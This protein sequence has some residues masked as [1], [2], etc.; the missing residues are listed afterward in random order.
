MLVLEAPSHVGDRPTLTHP[1]GGAVLSDLVRAALAK[2]HKVE[3]PLGAEGPW[4]SEATSSS[5]PARP[6]AWLPR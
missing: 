5:S 6:H 4:G 1:M 2:T 3:D